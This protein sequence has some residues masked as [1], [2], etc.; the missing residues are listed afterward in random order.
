M[1]IPKFI[2]SLRAKVGNH[3]LLVPTVVVM[4]RDK[5]GRLLLVQE[6]ESGLWGCPGGIIEPNE[7]PADAAVR[8]IWEESGILVELTRLLGVFGGDGCCAR[9]QNGDELAWVAT[10]FDARAVG[11][12][13]SPDGAE[14]RDARF[15]T[16]N[17]MITLPISSDAR[18]F[19]QATATASGDAYF[20]P[21]TWRP[22]E[23][24][25]LR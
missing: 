4:A 21:A 1:P 12:Q 24:E 13:P 23:I 18:L 8:E 3:L 16:A 11:G 14:T 22:S 2:A 25:R 7:V 15:F 6:H 19:L 20:K 17:E 10:V 5:E 9:Y